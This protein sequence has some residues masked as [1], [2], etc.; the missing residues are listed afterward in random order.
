MKAP[1][2]SDLEFLKESFYNRPIYKAEVLYKGEPL[3]G[4]SWRE[5][6][7]LETHGVFR[8]SDFTLSPQRRGFMFSTDIYNFTD[9]SRKIK[10]PKLFTALKYELDDR[11]R[12]D[13]PLT[14]DG[15]NSARS[16]D[17]IAASSLK[18]SRD[19]EK[20]AVAY[21]NG[22]TTYLDV[23]SD[24]AERLEEIS[25]AVWVNPDEVEG[26][27]SLVGKGEVFSAKIF[28]GH[29]QFTTKG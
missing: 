12:Y 3:D 13:F 16:D 1:F 2:I 27:R 8:T 4:V 22:E 20:G 11:L 7:H 25:I 23:R 17:Y 9:R 26:S 14:R 28:N 24:M 21:F 18:F 6:P 10:G 5:F 15:L 29:L 19:T